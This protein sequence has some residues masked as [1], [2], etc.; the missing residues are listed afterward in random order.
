LNKKWDGL[1]IDSFKV[2]ERTIEYTQT[3]A[4][5]EQDKNKKG[6]KKEVKKDAKK[7]GKAEEKT[8]IT[9]TNTKEI[10][11]FKTYR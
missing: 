9:T 6:A 10:K 8:E 3:E 1:L 11:S 5:Q 2:E 7:G 4:I